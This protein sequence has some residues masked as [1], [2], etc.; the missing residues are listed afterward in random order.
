[1]HIAANNN[2]NLKHTFAF[3]ETHSKNIIYTQFNTLKN[4]IHD[5][6]QKFN[7]NSNDFIRNSQ[8]RLDTIAHEVGSLS[9]QTK[10]SITDFH[11]EL[12]NINSELKNHIESFNAKYKWINIFLFSIF[13]LS[14]ISIL[15]NFLL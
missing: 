9:D 13:L 6:V 4:S 3:L 12:N 10:N 7:S 11:S 5:Q 2:I 8:S 14:T 1:M 15:I